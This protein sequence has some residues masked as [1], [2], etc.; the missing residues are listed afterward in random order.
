MIDE[1]QLMRLEVFAQ[2][3]T[4]GQFQMDSKAIMPMI[5]S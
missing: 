1:A 5:L 2:M 4:I 3:H